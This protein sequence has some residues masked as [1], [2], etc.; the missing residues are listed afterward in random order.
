MSSPDTRTHRGDGTRKQ[1]SRGGGRCSP[2]A[3]AA[4]MEGGPRGAT[5]GTA[6]HTHG[7]RSGLSMHRCLIQRMQTAS[8]TQTQASSEGRSRSPRASRC[9]GPGQRD[10][11]PGLF[12][13]SKQK[14]SSPGGGGAAPGCPGPWLLPLLG[15]APGRRAVASRAPGLA[16]GTLA[17]DDAKDREG[18]CEGA[19]APGGPAARVGPRGGAHGP[20]QGAHRRQPPALCL[21]GHWQ[22]RQPLC[23]HRRT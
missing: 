17:L 8:E 7:E 2:G 13:G 9:P 14:P 15:R 23:P 5:G 22:R 16:P 18:E 3:R 11:D 4:P 20:W 10:P 1:G 12:G 19:L 21:Q 6:L